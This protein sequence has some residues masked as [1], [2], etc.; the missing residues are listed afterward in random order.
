MNLIFPLTL[1]CG[2][3]ASGTCDCWK[4]VYQ[5]N[6]NGDSPIDRVLRDYNGVWRQTLEGYG[7]KLP[8]GRHHGPC[9]VCG[10]KDRFRFDDKDGRGTWFCS[11]CDPQSGGGLLL[12]SRYL[13]KPTIETAKELIGQDMPRTVAPVRKHS[14]TDEQMR[15]ELR[16]RA[17]RGAV[18][19]MEHSMPASHSYMNGKGLLGEWPVNSQ[20]MM[21]ADQERIE[22]GALL[23][24]PVYKSGELVNVQK[25]TTEGKKRPIYG[26]DMSGVCHVITGTGKI[27]AITEG[28]ATGVTVNRMTNAI[29]YVAFNT[30]NLM[31]ITAQARAENPKAN[32]VIFADNDEHGAGLKYAEEAAIPV[33][34]KIA[35]P[36]EIGDWDDYRQK[37]GTE[38]CKVAMREAIKLD[39]K[40]KQDSEH[41][42][43]AKKL[44]KEARELA[45]QIR[46]DEAKEVK[47]VEEPAS[48][49]ISGIYLPGCSPEEEVKVNITESD[50]PYHHKGEVPDGMDLSKI[51]IDNPPGLP[52][53][54][55]NYIRNGAHRELTGGA[56]AVMALQCIA[57]AAS[58]LKCYGGGKTSLITIILAL[59]GSGKE[60]AQSVIKSILTEA[61]RKVYGDIRSDKDV[62]MTTMYDAGRAAY[63]VDEA[64]KFLIQPKNSSSSYAANISTTLMELAT[65]DNFKPA[66]NHVGEVEATIRNS[67]SRLEKEKLA[68]EEC[69]GHCNPEYD[70]GKI[71][72][73]EMQIQKK[74]E[75]IATE[76]AAL[77]M[78][79]TGIPNPCLNLA[80]SSTPGKLSQMVNTD[81][82]DSGLLARAI[83]VDCGETRARLNMRLTGVDVSALNIHDRNDIIRDIAM[84]AADADKAMHSD[85]EREFNGGQPVLEV[86]A[87]EEATSAI[88]L[89]KLHYDQDR[90][91]NHEQIGSMYARI[92]ERV[93]SLSSLMA[94]GNINDGR[95]VIEVDY[96]IYSLALIIK[97][98]DNLISNLKLNAAVDGDDLTDKVNA[99]QEKILRRL[100]SSKG[101]QVFMAS[102]KQSIT[103]AAY[104]KEI[105][106]ALDGTG[107]DAFQNAITML[108][109]TGKIVVEGK[110]IR[111]P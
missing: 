109:M 67:L 55:V 42:A 108:Q 78:L 65:T 49:I 51:D 98:F 41:L 16:K 87:T 38:S 24:V 104:Y 57:I 85:A 26:G 80:G 62:I 102:V 91:R 39:G 17:K 77:H 59:S 36:P 75:R 44:A 21:G 76:E 43:A 81:N 83:V 11:Q 79:E 40:Q 70:E 86:I 8:N 72:Q 95:A 28:F 97:S 14:A 52:G 50:E 15:E 32:I 46:C 89:I 105:K 27:I 30:S 68:L 61:G 25:I 34:A 88:D 110:V 101:E 18:M 6:P 20:I 2:H 64:H 74:A 7:C 94:F 13:G 29:T 48:L 10:G 4:G 90:Y 35:L 58:G 9:P 37:Y 100:K 19:L 12:L 63:I 82:I 66:R 106:K 93:Q 99:I 84:I 103:K 60:R 5:F 107:Q 33:N 54:I 47:Q 56:Y 111:L 3:L 96:V 53:R 31:A 69:R 23:L 22:P 71:K 1:S 45:D 92:A 73:Y